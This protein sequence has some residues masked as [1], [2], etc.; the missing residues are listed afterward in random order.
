[1]SNGQTLCGINVGLA[2]FSTCT[3]DYYPCPLEELTPEH[4][5]KYYDLSAV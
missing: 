4:C 5:T 2:M 1:M 3:Y